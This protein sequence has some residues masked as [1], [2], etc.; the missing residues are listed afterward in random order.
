MCE[1]TCVKAR[2]R[3]FLF[4]IK[5]KKYEVD[6][7]SKEDMI[8]EVGRFN[9]YLQNFYSVLSLIN[10]ALIGVI[11]LSAS[12]VAITGYSERLSQILYVAGGV[13]FSARPLINALENF[14][15]REDRKSN[16]EYKKDKDQKD[17]G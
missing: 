16:I 3:V 9:L 5:R 17:E 4:N 7:R 11:Y 6:T 13:F 12:I 14:R 1:G 8:I 2:R 15:V 10:D